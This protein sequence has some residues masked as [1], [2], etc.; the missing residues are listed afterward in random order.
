MRSPVF[1]FWLL[2][3]CNMKAFSSIWT[4]KYLFS[5]SNNGL[6][7]T[8]G[9]YL[10]QF[11]PEMRSPVFLFW[12]LFQCNMKAF[13]S[14][15]TMKYLFSISNKTHCNLH[16]RWNTQDAKFPKHLLRGLKYLCRIWLTRQTTPYGS[17]NPYGDK[18]ANCQM[19]NFKAWLSLMGTLVIIR[20][21]R[22]WKY[23]DLRPNQFQNISSIGT[24]KKYPL[25][26]PILLIFHLHINI[27]HLHINN[28]TPWIGGGRVVRRCHVSCVTGA[29]NWY[30]LTA[31][32]GLLS[33]K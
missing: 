19:S 32:Q 20:M 31:G 10:F 4:M 29:S 21:P 16:L 2:F 22:I 33:L 28:Q 23:A 9:Y 12:L 25:C 13:S 15:W 24:H 11:H 30:W 3:Q 1:L 26:L 7:K 5:I 17:I 18:K 8:S 27:F 14:I 6:R